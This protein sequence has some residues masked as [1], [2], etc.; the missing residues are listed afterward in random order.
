MVVS[1]RWPFIGRTFG[2]MFNYRTPQTFDPKGEIVQDP[3]LY[4]STPTEKVKK[5]NKH[6]HLR[7]TSWDIPFAV[8]LPQGGATFAIQEGEDENKDPVLHIAI[9]ACSDHDNFDRKLGRKL[10]DERLDESGNFLSVMKAPFD[11][12]NKSLE[13]LDPC[14]AR[15]LLRVIA[16]L[17]RQGLV[18]NSE[19]FDVDPLDYLVRKHLEEPL[20]M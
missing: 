9:A 12:L 5:V 3:L 11:V 6:V 4:E 15:R 10:A 13:Q 14:V 19:N 16:I 2:R 17:Y 20:F 1:I 8:P 18:A 7:R